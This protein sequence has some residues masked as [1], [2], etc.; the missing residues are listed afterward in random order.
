MADP[1]A[2]DE[3]SMEEILASIRRIISEDG[4]EA[5]AESEAA[6][7][8]E[9]EPAAQAEPEPEPTPEPAQ[10]EPAQLEP[11]QLE[12][13]EQADEPSEDVLELTEMV[14]DQGNVVRLG[15]DEVPEELPQEEVAP[16]AE[17]DD[18]FSEAPAPEP[19]L[20]EPEQNGDGL[21]S[22]QAAQSAAATLAGL[23][24]GGAEAAGSQRISPSGRTIEE[25]VIELLKPMLR[26]WLDQNLP[27]IVERLVQREIER[28]AQRS[29]QP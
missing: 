15:G 21:V 1:K 2:Q 18:G 24:A 9:P 13:V 26:D 27:Q 16:A 3:P 4:E 11:A 6:P 19:S 10:A 5:S 7:E 23:A 20:A 29:N 22:D 12:P 14:D 25:Y 17:P 8:A 28:I